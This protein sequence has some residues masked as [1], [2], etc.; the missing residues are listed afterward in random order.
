MWVEAFGWAD[1][2]R[3]LPAHATTP[4]AIAS[5][6]KPFT[7]MAVAKLIADGRVSLEQPIERYIEGVTIRARGGFPVTVRQALQHQSGIPRHWRNFFAGQGKPPT[8]RNVAREHAFATAAQGKRYVYSNMNYG[9]LAAVVETVAGRPFHQFLNEIIFQP[10][11]ITTAKPLEAHFPNWHAAVPYEEDGT[12]IPPYLV[13]ETGARDLVMTAFDLA[14][15]G[16]ANLNGRLGQVSQLMLRH[17][18]PLSPSG[19]SKA[20]YGLGWVVEEDSPAALFSYGHTGEG[21]GA[22]ASLTIVPG[23][24]LVVATIASQQGAPAYML[25]EMIVD[26]MSPQFAARRKAHPFVSAPADEEALQSLAGRWEG[27][28]ESSSGVHLVWIEIDP[29][30]RSALSIGQQK[31][32]ITHLVVRDGVLTGRAEVTL[33]VPDAR[34][35]PH[36]SRLSVELRANE[37]DGTIA[38]YANRGKVAHDQFWLSYPLRLHRA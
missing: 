7:G 2:D 21:P 4:Y 5:A 29:S 38:A 1:R 20:S 31:S 16:L 27:R 36:Q 14:R 13:D 18:A 30:T 32:P 34:S 28:L 22:A 23:E 19:A 10:L 15:V 25:N 17:R 12:P 8:F 3:R 6:S 11:A 33:P 35:W 26:A 24:E 37:L 9:L